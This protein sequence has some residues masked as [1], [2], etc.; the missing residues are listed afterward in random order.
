[1]AIKQIHGIVDIRHIVHHIASKVLLID[2][3]FLWKM[4]VPMSIH[5]K[6]ASVYDVLQ[7]VDARRMKYAIFQIHSVKTWR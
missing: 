2:T 4:Y 7:D 1:M 6:G 3:H 5:Y